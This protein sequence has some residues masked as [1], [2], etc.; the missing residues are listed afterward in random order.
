MEER[1]Q[2]KILI[3]DDTE[4]NLDILTE[5]LGGA[6]DLTVTMDGERALEIVE[7]DPPDLILLDVMMPKLDGYE[8]C[9]RLK[10]DKETRHIPVIFL[11]ALS[12]EEN[13]GKG[14][15]YGA[16]DYITKPFNIEL[17][18]V[19]VRNHL[20]LKKHRDGLEKLVR[21]RTKDL[22]LT[23]HATIHALGTLAEFRDPETGGHIKR[24]QNYV[25]LLAL[26][27]KHHRKFEDC[28]DNE[29][30]DYLFESAP[31][32]DIGKVGISDAI[33][34]KAGKLTEAE[35]AE[36]K[37]HAAYGHN[38]ILKVEQDLGEITTS[39]LRFGKEIA[40][41]HHEKWDGSGYPKGLAGDKIPFSGRLMAVADVYDALVSKRV[42]KPPFSHK[43]AVSMMTEGK[44]KHFD[45]DMLDA[46]LELNE[47]FRKIAL[48][49]ADFEEEKKTLSES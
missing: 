7:K 10:A 30:I 12:D 38:A 35:F 11:T 9:Q 20:E 13:E 29:T 43:K 22:I 19:R 15:Q 41:T 16:V 24:T 46:F 28:L 39:F 25:R 34:L 44:G 36:M 42:Y 47:E 33:L 5:A 14:L 27:L 37:K 6:Y 26:R 18:K 17:V 2:A 3:A 8:V 23:Q 49:Y 21:E 48:K 40:I 45:P 1:L 31:L 4:S 32:H